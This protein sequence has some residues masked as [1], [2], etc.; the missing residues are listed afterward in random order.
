MALDCSPRRC[1]K[2]RSLVDRSQPRDHGP[3]S[4]QSCPTATAPLPGDQIERCYL[5]RSWGTESRKIS[6]H[7]SESFGSCFNRDR[8]LAEWPHMDPRKWPHRPPPLTVHWRGE[9]R[10]Y[11]RIAQNYRP[12]L[13]G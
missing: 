9:H 10:D 3:P 7:F 4:H 12:M 11:F 13:L 5:E 6:L 1:S 2:P 8:L